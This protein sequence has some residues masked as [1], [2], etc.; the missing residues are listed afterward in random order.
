ME[1]LFTIILRDKLCENEK[2]VIDNTNNNFTYLKKIRDLL[3]I[4]Q[5]DSFRIIYTL[6]CS[7][8]VSKFLVSDRQIEVRIF[9]KTEIEEYV[10][11]AL[12]RT[13]NVYLFI[14]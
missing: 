8:Y 7:T 14:L 5:H 12:C 2:K 10:S 4:N 3:I 11:Y 13:T 6:S 9:T 1:N